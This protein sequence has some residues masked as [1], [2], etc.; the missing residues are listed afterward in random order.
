MS[1][2]D[3]VTMNLVLQQ[4]ADAVNPQQEKM[5]VLLWDNAGWHKA[6]DLAVPPGIVLFPIPAY[7]PELSPAEPI[8][9]LLHEAMAN[10]LL[11]TL[12]QLQQRLVQRCLFL[13]QHW[14]VVKAAC[15]FSW[16]FLHKPS[17]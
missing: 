6:K 10:Q 14:A 12:E 16:T 2:V 17:A 5:I 8:V 13:Q 15:G 4:F 1:H 9:P 11:T 3:T 7:T